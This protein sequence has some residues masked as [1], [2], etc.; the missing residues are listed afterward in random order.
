MTV[1]MTFNYPKEVR[2]PMRSALIQMAYDVN[3]THDLTLCFNDYY[4]PDASVFYL[5]KWYRHMMQRLFRRRCYQLPK[6]QVIEFVAFPECPDGGNPHFHCPIRIPDSHLNYFTKIAETRWK[7]I[8]PKGNIFLQPI[9]QTA[10][11]YADL[12]DYVTKSPSAKDV[13]HSSMLIPIT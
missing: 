4:R 8:V 6:Q 13:I 2:T 12:F 10:K 5:A 7:A 3:A 1:T 11:D 9:R